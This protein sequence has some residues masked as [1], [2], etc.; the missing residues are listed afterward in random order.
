MDM[1]YCR[2]IFASY[3]H[4]CGISSEAIDFLQGRSSTSVLTRH[5]L[6]LDASLK[7]RIL[8]SN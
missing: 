6:T 7:N 4:Q 1:C 2:K 3:L 8:E 5:Y